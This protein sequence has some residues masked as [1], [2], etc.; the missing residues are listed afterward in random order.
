MICFVFFFFLREESG[1]QL[2]RGLGGSGSGGEDE[3]HGVLGDQN[4]GGGG[5]CGD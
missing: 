1:M 2:V 5:G 4:G 3:G